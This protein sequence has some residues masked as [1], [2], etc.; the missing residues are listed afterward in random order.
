M[1]CPCGSL[2]AI[3]ECCLPYIRQRSL[4]S[5]AEQL[6]RSR[7]TAYFIADY[8]YILNTYNFHTR[9]DMSATDLKDANQGTQWL[10]LEVRG[11]SKQEAPNKVEFKAYYKVTKDI[12]CMHEISNFSKVDGQW[13]YVDGEMLEGTGILKIKRNEACICGSKKKFKHCCQA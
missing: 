4:P 9:P 12:Y 10:R 13:Q 6:M 1:A 3:Q 11:N 7:Y 5:T 8:E 2:L